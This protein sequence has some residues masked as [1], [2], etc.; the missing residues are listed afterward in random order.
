MTIERDARRISVTA[1]TAIS[2]LHV[3]WGLGSTWPLPD[4]ETYSD[5]VIGRPNP[6]GPVACFA[7]AGALGTAAL[8]VAG[9]PRRRPALSRI[10]AAG[11][12]GVLA[13]RGAVG[14][15]GRTDLLSPGSVSPRFRR[16]DRLAYSPL[17]L[18]LATSTAIATA[19][20]KG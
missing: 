19:R 7:V 18:A 3:A 12:A 6:P 8:L 16:L 15:S 10:G 5:V 13:L 20:R 2:G 9:R 11:V 14:L 4:R 17:C 1:L